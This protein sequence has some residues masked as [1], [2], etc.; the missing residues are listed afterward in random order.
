MLTG[1]DSIDDLGVLREG[2]V[3]KATAAIT[4]A[5]G[6]EQSEGCRICIRRAK[7]LCARAAQIESGPGNT[8]FSAAS[9][10]CGPLVS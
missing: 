10:A 4:A 7:A 5:V 8:L 2:A 1:A 6:M 3:H 9:S